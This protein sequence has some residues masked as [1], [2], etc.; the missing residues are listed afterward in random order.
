MSLHQ[1]TYIKFMGLV[2]MQLQVGGVLASTPAALGFNPGL[3]L[4]G[5][6]HG[7]ISGSR[8]QARSQGV[9]FLGPA[10]EGKSKC[11]RSVGFIIS[12]LATLTWTLV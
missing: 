11:S 6:M 7:S 4:C 9:L 2:F 10:K 5:L 12:F 8:V 1:V 3:G